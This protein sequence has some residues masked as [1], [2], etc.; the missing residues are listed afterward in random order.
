MAYAGE[1]VKARARVAEL[2]ATTVAVCCPACGHTVAGP[3][4]LGR[5]EDIFGHDWEPHQVERVGKK[6]TVFECENCLQRFRLPARLH[7]LRVPIA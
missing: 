3:E 4:N 5:D 7:R 2:V 6:G 1:E